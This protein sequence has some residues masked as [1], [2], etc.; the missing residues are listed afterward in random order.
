MLWLG[1]PIDCTFNLEQVVLVEA[2]LDT[3]TPEHLGFAMERLFA[4]GA[5]DVT[6][7]PLQMKK[8]RPGTLLSALVVPERA[9]R[10]AEVML[11][12][13][14]T[15]GVRMLPVG[16]MVAERHVETVQTPYGAVRLK[17][18]HLGERRIPAPEYE[19]CAAC[20]REHHVPLA[21]VYRAAL[22][23]SLR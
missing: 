23:A 17:I 15:L 4:A 2:N 21:E 6:F 7:A 3:M 12:E 18:K 8:N 9:A 22:Q 16:R 20:A 14:T 19:D 10:I 11:Q 5:L 1:E 13:T